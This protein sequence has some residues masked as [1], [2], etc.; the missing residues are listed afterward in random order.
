MK[1]VVL[2]TPAPIEEGPL[3]LVDLPVPAP[4]PGQ[5]VMRVA[6]C[7]V[8]RSN[9]HMV[10]GEWAA[11][12]VPAKSPIVP[13]HEVVGTVAEVG[14][15]VVGFAEGDRVG[16]QPLWST[17]GRCEYCLDGRD[18]LCQAKEIG[19]ESVD[20]GYAE[21]M[22]ANAAHTYLLPDELGFVEAASL[23]C[24]GITAYGSVLK[25][26][27]APGRTLAVF[28]VGGVGHMVVQFARLYGADVVAVSR[29]A[30]HLA[31]A[32]ELGA[33][34]LVDAGADDA[35]DVLSRDGGV[36]ASVVLAPSDAVMAQ[37]IRATKPGGT[38]VSAVN[39]TIGA[40]PFAVERTLVGSLLGS[41]RQMRTVLELAAAGKVGVVAQAYPLE[42]AQ[43]VLGRLKAGEIRA[44]A[45]LTVE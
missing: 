40:F 39:A 16:V 28:G 29:G 41:R 7:G 24:P 19:G 35:G 18:Q 11:A 43:D 30:E 27:P 12:G 42:Q 26:R 6:A 14:E 17:C 9:L 10:E 22:L 20:G 33:T 21:Y 5:V 45:V 38:V 4:G 25:A 2:R 44:R 31:V 36:D 13:G 8:C 1:A 32:E 3:E 34:R 37:A 23:F 15:G